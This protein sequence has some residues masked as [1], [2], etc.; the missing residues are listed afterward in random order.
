MALINCPECGKE[1]SDKAGN[2]P[3]CGCLIQPEQE[4][5]DGKGERWSFEKSP[6]I[7]EKEKKEKPK[8]KKRMLE[9]YTDNCRN[10]HSY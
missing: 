3:N 7:T 6:K 1:I 5:K 10:L 2:C 9:N 4:T 8:K